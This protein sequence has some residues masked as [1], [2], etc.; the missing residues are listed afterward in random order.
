MYN[1]TNCYT[2]SKTMICGTDSYDV[3]ITLSCLRFVRRCMF[4]LR[5]TYIHVHIHV[6]IVCVCSLCSFLWSTS[7]SFPF[8]PLSFFLHVV[9]YAHNCSY[10]VYR[11]CILVSQKVFVMFVCIAQCMLSISKVCYVAAV[12]INGCNCLAA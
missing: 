7:F 5:N 1:V 2:K 11:L 8:F 6:C 12:Y 4:L 3:F 9:C 10:I